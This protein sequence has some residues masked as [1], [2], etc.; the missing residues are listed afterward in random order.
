MQVI[1]SDSNNT[2][3]T[4]ESVSQLNVVKLRFYT[5]YELVSQSHLK[6]DSPNL[7]HSVLLW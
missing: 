3:L 5:N 4:I 7:V 2:G 6:I 1:I